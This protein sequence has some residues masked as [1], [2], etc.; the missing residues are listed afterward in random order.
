MNIHFRPDK[1]LET[2]FSSHEKVFVGFSGGKDSTVLVDLC[3][4]WAS[5]ITLVSVDTGFLFPHMKRRIEDYGRVFNLVWVHSDQTEHWRKHGL[6]SRVIP[7]ENVDLY[8]RGIFISPKMQAWQLCCSSLIIGPLN[9]FLQ[10]Q[11]NAVFLHGQ[12]ISEIAPGHHPSPNAFEQGS[13]TGDCTIYA[14]LR[15]W[16]EVDILSYL[17]SRNIELPVQYKYGKSDFSLDC[18]NCPAMLLK[19]RIKFMKDHYPEY[20]MSAVDHLKVTHRAAETAIN[21]IAGMI[22]LAKA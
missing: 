13:K 1:L 21:E 6:P 10:S 5:Q 4:P 20:L 16:S 9:N 17:E 7:P 8:G 3:K 15:D 2:I 11:E 14:P 19:P 18:W 22:E 12:R